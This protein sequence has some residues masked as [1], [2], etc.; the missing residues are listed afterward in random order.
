MTNIPTIHD[1]GE[2]LVLLRESALTRA[3]TYI[4]GKVAV[5]E[6]ADNDPAFPIRPVAWIDNIGTARD[7]LDKAYDADQLRRRSAWAVLPL[8]YGPY[9]STWVL[10]DH[11]KAPTKLGLD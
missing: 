5:C 1:A 4:E 2:L 11:P 7:L 10:S 8:R 6:C 3:V 9:C